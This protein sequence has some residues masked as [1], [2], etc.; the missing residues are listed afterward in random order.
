MDKLKAVWA[1]I[2]SHDKSSLFSS[3][4]DPDQQQQQQQ[5]PPK[6]SLN[7][8]K[9]KMDSRL[10]D[11]KPRDFVKD[12]HAVFTVPDDSVLASAASSFKILFQCLLDK[13]SV[14][15]GRKG[16]SKRSKRSGKR[17]AAKQQHQA[18]A[19]VFDFVFEDD[20]SSED[21][22]LAGE[23]LSV[24]SDSSGEEED[25]YHRRGGLFGTSDDDDDD[26]DDDDSSRDEFVPLTFSFEQE[27]ILDGLSPLY[28]ELIDSYATSSRPSPHS[29]ADDGWAEW[30][31]PSNPASPKS[32]VSEGGADDDDEDDI[33]EDA[34]PNHHESD[35][36][37]DDIRQSEDGVPKTVELDPE[38]VVIDVISHDPSVATTTRIIAVATTQDDGNKAAAKSKRAKRQRTPSV[39]GLPMRWTK[40]DLLFKITN[41]LPSEKL[42]GIILIVNPALEYCDSDD[43]DLEFDINALDEITLYRLQEYVHACLSGNDD[44]DQGN[45]SLLA[46]QEIITITQTITEETPRKKT[47]TRTKTSVA[48]SALIEGDTATPKK[49]LRSSQ[50]RKNASPAKT[51]SPTV[52]ATKS[53]TKKSVRGA[54]TTTQVIE[55]TICH[56]VEQDDHFNYIPHSRGA[57][58][59]TLVPEAFEVFR[60]E[61]VIKVQK[62]ASE[63]DMEEEVDI[64][65]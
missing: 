10:Y 51:T 15:L 29:S 25:L 28:S 61:Q 39:R 8:V 9:H 40:E 59:N 43:E 21:L 34:E 38:D 20:L 65:V 13:H 47:K 36:A 2:Q 11:K 33:E 49:P 32:A 14:N 24:D 12:M 44:G 45:E 46:G 31:A 5:Q 57:R 7:L 62:A 30:E 1:E 16:S 53:K 22:L 54:T 58:L 55:T 41:E 26:D 63:S 19:D 50:R 17:A 18:P 37:D 42:E 64:I 3:A 23:F 52:G 60:T 48:A 6:M 35:E 56:F 27:G 4:G